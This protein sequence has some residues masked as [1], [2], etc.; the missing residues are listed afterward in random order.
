MQ[1]RTRTLEGQA[2][3]TAIARA[4]ALTE[5][6]SYP[7]VFGNGAVVAQGTWFRGKPYVTRKTYNDW[8]A[9]CEGPA[10]PPSVGVWEPSANPLQ[11]EEFFEKERISVEWRVTSD[12]G[13]WSASCLL[14]DRYGYEGK[15]RLQA[16]GRCYVAIKL[17]DYL[18]FQ[19]AEATQ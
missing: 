2:L 16:A 3:D 4:I 18:E 15:T 1:V 6:V 11:V 8:N 19:D 17:G 7:A 13:Y 9:L 12:G 14:Y 5:P 10:F